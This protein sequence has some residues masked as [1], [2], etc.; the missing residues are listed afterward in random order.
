MT[1]KIKTDD[2]IYLEE[3]LF[4]QPAVMRQFSSPNAH[5]SLPHDPVTVSGQ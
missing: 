1:G 2:E 5:D 4:S 3:H